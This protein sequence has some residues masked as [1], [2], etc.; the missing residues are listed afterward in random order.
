MTLSSI[1]QKIESEVAKAKAA[2]DKV[3]K[4][5]KEAAAALYVRVR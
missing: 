5:S 1:Q 3:G 4:T 2:S